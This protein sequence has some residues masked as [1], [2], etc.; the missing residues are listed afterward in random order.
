MDLVTSGPV[1]IHLCPGQTLVLKQ[2]HFVSLATPRMAFSDTGQPFDP[3]GAMRKRRRGGK[4][5]VELTAKFRVEDCVSVYTQEFVD[6]LANVHHPFSEILF[7]SDGLCGS[8][9]DTA[10]RTAYMLSKKIEHQLEHDARSSSQMSSPPSV[11]FM[12]FGGLGGSADDAKRSL[13]ATA[14]PGGNVMSS[15]MGL[16]YNPIFSA[17]ALGYLAAAWAGLEKM[18]AEIHVFRERVPQYPYYWEKLPKYPQSEIY[19]NALGPDALPSEYYFFPTDLFL[20]EWYAD[21]QGMPG[22]WNETELKRLHLDAAKG[23]GSQPNLRHLDLG[24]F[25]SSSCGGRKGGS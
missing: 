25:E 22:E 3:F 7:V 9:C 13:S 15:A 10:S 19:Q 8:S 18:K 4:E 16:L 17:A 1:H 5:D 23:F 21:V 20:P 12:T 6:A 14:Y 24:R 11:R 2:F